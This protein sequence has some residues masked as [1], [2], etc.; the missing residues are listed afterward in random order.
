MCSRESSPRNGIGFRRRPGQI[1]TVC[2]E[3][4][5][6]PAG[7]NAGA[8]ILLVGGKMVDALARSGRWNDRRALRMPTWIEARGTSER[9]VAALNEFERLRCSPPVDSELSAAVD[10]ARNLQGGSIDAISGRSLERQCR[11]F[12]LVSLRE[13]REV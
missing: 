4:L 11:S 8:I 7:A 3:I 5:V 10:M 12:L 1:S 13:A 2:R 6:C 9:Y